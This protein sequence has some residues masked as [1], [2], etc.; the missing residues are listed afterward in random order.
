MSPRVQNLLV[1]AYG[2]VEGLLAS[3]GDGII[4]DGFFTWRGT[5]GTTLQVWNN[6]NHQTTYGVLGVVIQ[7]LQWWMAAN[8]FMA[9]TFDIYDGTN[10]VGSGEVV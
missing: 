6:N 1:S 5:R 10:Q 7:A 4:A 2:H 9:V 8:E 3:D